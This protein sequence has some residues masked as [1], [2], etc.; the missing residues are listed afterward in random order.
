LIRTGKFLRNL[1][2]AAVA[3]C[4][5]NEV[6]SLLDAP[7]PYNA[8]PIWTKSRKV[9]CPAGSIRSQ[10]YLLIIAAKKWEEKIKEVI[11]SAR[12]HGTQRALAGVLI[13]HL[14]PRSEALSDGAPDGT[15]H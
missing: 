6:T 2:S 1:W 3:Y 9:E 4:L 15:P 7:T 14:I 13:R 10:T 11:G 8:L 5:N 12:K